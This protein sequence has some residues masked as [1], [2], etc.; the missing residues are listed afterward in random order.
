[1]LRLVLADI[2][3]THN[4]SWQTTSIEGE[5]VVKLV[6]WF[7]TLVN[8]VGKRGIFWGLRR[9]L[10]DGKGRKEIMWARDSAVCRKETARTMEKNHVEPYRER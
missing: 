4:R 2:W 10:G 6:V 1:M 9:L 3:F 5:L 8:S 7:P